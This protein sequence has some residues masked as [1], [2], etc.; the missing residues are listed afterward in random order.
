MF[1]VNGIILK[2]AVIMMK[3]CDESNEEIL[4]RI[5]ISNTYENESSV[6]VQAELSPRDEAW[7]TDP[8]DWDFLIHQDFLPDW[9]E[10]GKE[11]YELKFREEVKRWWDLHLLVN[12]KFETISTGCYMLTGCMVERLSGDAL[13]LL[14]D[15]QVV[16]MSGKSRIVE[17]TGGSCVET[18]QDDASVQ[19]MKENS[20][21]CNMYD[22]SWVE[23]MENDSEVGAMKDKSQIEEMFHQSKVRVLLDRSRILKMDDES[24]VTEMTDFSLIER[25]YGSTVLYMTGNS[26]IEALH[27]GANVYKMEGNS[28][29]EDLCSGIVERMD[30]SSR[31][32]TMNGRSRVGEMYGESQIEKLSDRS[33]AMDFKSSPLIKI[34]VP[35][36]D[37][38]FELVVQKRTK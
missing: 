28:H 10:K 7:W 1:G 18:M 12:R 5:G 17:M 23:I 37:Y 22:S 15:S 20:E 31:I 2:E 38:K 3:R 4:E 33:I 16:E 27:C 24:F 19:I 9:F 14:K 34:L 11:E 6:F 8:G 30:D 29:I 36:D 32:G 35:D 13:V 25:M 21:I 26:K